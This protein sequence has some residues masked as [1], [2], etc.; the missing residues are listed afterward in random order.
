MRTPPKESP[1]ILLGLNRTRDGVHQRPLHC[2]GV[3]QDDSRWTVPP[4]TSVL[5]S[6][7]IVCW[8]LALVVLIRLGWHDAFLRASDA[9]RPSVT[10]LTIEQAAELAG[11]RGDLELSHLQTV[12]PQVADLLARSDSAILLN[13]LAALS[14]EAAAA[15]S[16]PYAFVELKPLT[17]LPL[18]TALALI[19]PPVRTG[20]RSRG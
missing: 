3:F 20:F 18:D 19:P 8:L 1:T 14:A 4:P 9:D 5:L 11:A 6:H 17:D 12:S 2:R 10:Q 15:P 7:A 16:Q 13:G